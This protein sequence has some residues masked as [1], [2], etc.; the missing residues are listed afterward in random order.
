MQ[1]YP[2]EGFIRQVLFCL[3]NVLINFDIGLNCKKSLKTGRRKNGYTL[4]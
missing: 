4:A 2:M 3:G 1:T